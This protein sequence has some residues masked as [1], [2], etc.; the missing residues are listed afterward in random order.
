[1]NGSP[2]GRYMHCTLFEAAARILMT[3]DEDVVAAVKAAFRESGMVVV[4]SAG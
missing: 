4:G 1:M 3:E 2:V